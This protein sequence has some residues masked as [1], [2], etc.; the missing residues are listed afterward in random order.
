MVGEVVRKLCPG[1]VIPAARTF[2]DFEWALTKTKAPGIITLFGD[3]NALPG[4][5]AEARRYEKKLIIHLDLLEGI[6]KDKA[7]VK[8][9]ARMGLPA[10]ITTKTQLVQVAR[11]EGMIVVQRLFLMD[12]E[13]LR[14][15]IRMVRNFKPDAIE[16]LPAAVP[17]RVF[18]E[19]AAETGL[20]IFAGGL[21]STKEDV[22]GALANG[23]SAVSSSKRELWC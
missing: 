8:C 7:G 15:G 11:D 22:A 14:T 10:L 18:Q 20:P 4:L 21:V 16:V 23:A 6:G 3:I 1:P 17:K 5:L 13:A 2:S 9:L 12:S 19:L